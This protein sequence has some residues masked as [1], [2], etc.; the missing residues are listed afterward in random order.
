MLNKISDNIWTVDG[1]AVLFYGMPY[2]TRM[3]LVRLNNGMLWVHSPSKISDKLLAEIS[4]L[5][6][7]KYLISPNKL[8]YL[9]LLDWIK[10]FPEAVCYAPPG[11]E[12]KRPDI[13]FSKALGMKP[14]NEWQEEIDQIIFKG[15][16]AM[17]EVVFFHRD[18]KTLIL[19]DL[20]ENFKPESFNWWQRT[21]AKYA[22]ILS[23]NGKTPVDWRFSFV[24]GK[25]EAKIS[26]ASL[27]EWEPENIIVSHGECIF[28]DGL[29]F[30][31]KSFSWV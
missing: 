5:G 1:D 16:P 15:S 29:E 11:L 10:Q 25:K 14:E 13:E 17:E 23:P 12:K 18:S 3:T 28:G 9:F 20:I 31:K 24:F 8:H 7:V 22:G 27:L 6:E 19:T 4:A 2:T 30:L 26:L 21:L